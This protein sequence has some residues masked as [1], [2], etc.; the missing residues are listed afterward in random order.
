MPPHHTSYS[1]ETRPAS[2][3]QLQSRQ[4]ERAQTHHHATS[5]H[6]AHALAPRTRDELRRFISQHPIASGHVVA[7]SRLGSLHVASTTMR[8]SKMFARYECTPLAYHPRPIW[9]DCPASCC[10]VLGEGNCG[11]HTSGRFAT[12]ARQAHASTFLRSIRRGPLRL[13]RCCHSK[14]DRA[15]IE[16]ARHSSRAGAH[17]RAHFRGKQNESSICVCG[18]HASSMP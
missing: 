13:A 12:S 17:G 2:S 11:T 6:I 8:P 3:L 7:T 9:S 10:I 14:A 4:P 1:H 16:P 15:R 5:T 18:R